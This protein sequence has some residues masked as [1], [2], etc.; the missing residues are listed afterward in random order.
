[1]MFA[2]FV[3]GG[4]HF[5]SFDERCERETREYTRKQCPRRLDEFTIMD[6]TVYDM[7]TRTITYYYTCEGTLDNADNLTEE[8][9]RT[10]REQLRKNVVNSIELKAYKEKGLNFC[11]LYNS[12]TT[13]KQLLKI[14]IEPKDYDKSNRQD[15]EE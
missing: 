8:V 9:I 7:G 12:C 15:S 3:V 11:Y 6:S 1:M 13:G 10:C 2:T 4:C 14:T 5:E